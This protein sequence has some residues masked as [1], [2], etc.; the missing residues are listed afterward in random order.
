MGD[1]QVPASLGSRV[2]R[3]GQGPHPLTPITCYS[4]Q[5][6]SLRCILLR[7]AL[8]RVSLQG[9]PHAALIDSSWGWGTTFTCSLGTWAQ[10]RA[11]SCVVTPLP[12]P[13]RRHLGLPY[14]RSHLR[15]ES[16]PWAP[17]SGWGA[18]GPGPRAATLRRDRGGA[19]GALPSDSSGRHRRG[20]PTHLRA[21]GAP[22]LSA[23][24]KLVS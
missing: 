5:W 24:N 3:G 16:S 20:A 2:C 23:R 1:F 22:R 17:A 14:A 13:S 19:G 12:A 18:A 8:L 6:G 7:A 11:W 10:G 21:P 15:A 4:R 9:G